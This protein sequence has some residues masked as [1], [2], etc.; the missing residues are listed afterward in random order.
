MEGHRLGG[1]HYNAG[2][3]QYFPPERIE[4]RLVKFHGTGGQPPQIHVGSPLEKHPPVIVQ[5]DGADPG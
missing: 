3:L 1:L 4:G 5:Y 2:L